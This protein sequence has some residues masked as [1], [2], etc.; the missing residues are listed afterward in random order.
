L[1]RDVLGM[2]LLGPVLLAFSLTWNFTLGEAR[3][4]AIR[5]EAKEFGIHQRV[6]YRLAHG[7]LDAAEALDL[8][9]GQTQARHLQELAANPFKRAMHRQSN[10]FADPAISRPPESSRPA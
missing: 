7:V 2:A 5:P 8:P 4:R 10:S 1:L 9:D 3:V 6:E